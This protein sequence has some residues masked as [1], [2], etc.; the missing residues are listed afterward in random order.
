MP[1]AE[2][3]DWCVPPASA[4]GVSPGCR[5][6]APEDR[7]QQGGP[8]AGADLAVILASPEAG[9]CQQVPPS[10]ASAEHVLGFGHLSAHLGL[11]DT[12]DNS[13]PRRQAA[14][15]VSLISK[16]RS[17]TRWHMLCRW[18]TRLTPQPCSRPERE[19]QGQKMAPK[20]ESHG[21]GHGASGTRSL[22]LGGSRGRPQVASVTA[23]QVGPPGWHALARPAVAV[24]VSG[25]RGVQ[26][27]PVQSKVLPRSR[28][29]RL[30]LQCPPS[31]PTGWPPEV[32]RQRC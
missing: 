19:E 8:Q 5:K 23:E 22:A 7:Q 20:T 9:T 10:E 16:A 3:R 18:V 1:D 12:R 21:R 25:G 11:I 31:P 26:T 32:L 2:S 15:R 17:R 29:Q 6:M 4:Q 28:G 14:V 13:V 27:C 24:D 30:S